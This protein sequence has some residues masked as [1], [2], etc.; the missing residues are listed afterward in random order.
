MRLPK[1]LMAI[2]WTMHIIGV[3]TCL[4]LLW[5]EG[6]RAVLALREVVVQQSPRARSLARP[7]SFTWKERSLKVGATVALQR[8]QP[9]ARGVVERLLSGNVISFRTDRSG[10]RA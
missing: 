3:I 4:Y 7:G 5:H 9:F 10:S 1:A 8:H 6:V 2:L